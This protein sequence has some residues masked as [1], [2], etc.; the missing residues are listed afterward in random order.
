MPVQSSSDFGKLSSLSLQCDPLRQIEISQLIEF[1]SDDRLL[2]NEKTSNWNFDDF[3]TIRE[4]WILFVPKTEAEQVSWMIGTFR[5][6]FS[7]WHEPMKK[8]IKFYEK[9]F[10][11]SK[12]WSVVKEALLTLASP[13][14]LPPHAPVVQ[15]I[16]DQRWLIANSEK[17]G[18]FF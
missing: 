10:F 14:A 7:T 11:P 3:W 18:T 8:F 9:F 4:F 1:P 5:P 12:H 13:I 15:K 17:I 6:S 16:A 2:S